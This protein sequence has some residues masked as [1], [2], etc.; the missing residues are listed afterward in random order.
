MKTA[1]WIT[2][3]GRALLAALDAGL[4][5]PNEGGGVEIDAF[6]RFWSAMEREVLPGLVEQAI[7]EVPRRKEARE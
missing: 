6:E 7:K 2:L 3:K 4:L 1:M 5:K